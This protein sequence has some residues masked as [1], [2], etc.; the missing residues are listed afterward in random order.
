[1]RA[2][3]IPQVPGACLGEEARGRAQRPLYYVILYHIILYYIILYYIIIYKR[4]V[5]GEGVGAAHGVLEI[6]FEIFWS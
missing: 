4:A 3:P 6:H 5:A 2:S 1:M